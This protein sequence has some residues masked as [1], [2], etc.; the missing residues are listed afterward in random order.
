MPAVTWL[1]AGL[2]VN[3]K[4]FGRCGCF[5]KGHLS[6]VRSALPFNSIFASRDLASCEMR[7]V[8]AS[9]SR[10]DSAASLAMPSDS[11]AG[12]AIQCGLR[13]QSARSSYRRDLRYTLGHRKRRRCSAP[14]RQDSE[15]PNRTAHRLH[16]DSTPGATGSTHLQTPVAKHCL[17]T[18][19]FVRGRSS[20]IPLFAKSAWPDPKTKTCR[21][22]GIALAQLAGL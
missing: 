13:C 15:T 17:E 22:S 4:P 9:T 11:A 3:N 19:C 6:G 10:Y 1:G 16:P 12:N 14:D 8:P 21:S 2:H 5:R 20:T 18:P 7:Q